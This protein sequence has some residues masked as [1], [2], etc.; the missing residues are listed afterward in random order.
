MK[1]LFLCMIAAVVLLGGCAAKTDV[2]MKVGDVEVKQEYIDYF[3][4]YFNNQS[5]GTV[6]EA[7]SAG[8]F[9]FVCPDPGAGE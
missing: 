6:S 5:G 1:R 3:Q 4:Q 2:V 9:V 8:G 7:G